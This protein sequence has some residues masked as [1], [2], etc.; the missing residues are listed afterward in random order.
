MDSSSNSIVVH[1]LEGEVVA[2]EL[3]WD[4]AGSDRLLDELDVVVL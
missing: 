3:L 4:V 2:F 1:R